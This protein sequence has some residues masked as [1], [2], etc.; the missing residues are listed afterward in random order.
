[1]SQQPSAASQAKPAIDPRKKQDTTIWW[2]NEDERLLFE[3][4]LRDTYGAFDENG[5][6]E[7][8]IT[9]EVVVPQ[10]N[11]R[12]H[13]IVLG[14]PQRRRFPMRKTIRNP[15][16]Q[17]LEAVE[18]PYEELYDTIKESPI[19]SLQDFFVGGGRNRLGTFD[20]N[21]FFDKVAEYSTCSFRYQ[22]KE[23]VMRLIGVS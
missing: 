20:S 11:P 19:I 3:A 5:D 15:T 7:A 9:T 8:I 4:Y 21:R 17:L 16:S 13:V 18:V 12:N 10:L 1:M 22:P 23:M 14:R 6:F 2:C